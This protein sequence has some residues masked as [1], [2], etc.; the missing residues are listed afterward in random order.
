MKSLQIP[1]LLLIIS[2]TDKKETRI[3]RPQDEA[4]QHD[5]KQPIKKQDSAFASWLE[6]YQNENPTFAENNF[7][8]TSTSQISYDP[9]NVVVMNTK[10]FNEI[11]RPFFVFNESRTNYLDFDS[12]HWSVAK[13]GNASFNADQ[14]VALIDMKKKTAVQISF[15]GPSYTVEEAYWKGDSAAVLLGNS[16]EQVPFM[17][18]FNFRKNTVQHYQYPDTLKFDQPYYRVR[19]Q[20]LGIK[21]Q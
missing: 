20:N 12:Y 18:K 10:G 9:S 16:Y 21:T 13:D 5:V 11:Y 14:Q 4:T 2:C 8:L 6:Y 15:F 17:M 7:M 1:L 19:L 3:P